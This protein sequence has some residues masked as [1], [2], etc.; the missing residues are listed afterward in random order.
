MII[1]FTLFMLFS[2]LGFVSGR[3]ITVDDDGGADFSRIQPAIDNATNGDTINVWEG[4]YQGH[5]WVN[6]SIDLHGNASNNTIIDGNGSK[7]AILISSD[8]VNI[9][10]FNIIHSISGIGIESSH[11]QILDNNFLLH[12]NYGIEILGSDE[13]VIV[14]NE[15]RDCNGSGISITQ[16]QDISISDNYFSDNGYGVTGK[17]VSESKIKNNHFE[18]HFIGIYLDF[19]ENIKI[20]NNGFFNNTR[21]GILIFEDNSDDIQIKDNAFG[22]NRYDV[23]RYGTETENSQ[24]GDLFTFYSVIIVI[25]MIIAVLVIFLRN[26]KSV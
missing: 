10:G 11:V 26:E 7:Y 20:S 5:I 13:I 16:G 18:Y 12:Q 19:S 9:S 22:G 21:A 24:L 8:Y 25:S 6:N 1:G 15:F 23:R 3:T 14:K 2:G 17:E 4:I